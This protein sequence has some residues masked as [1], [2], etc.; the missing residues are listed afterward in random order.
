MRARDTF[1]RFNEKYVVDPVTGCWMW[2]DRPNKDGY[3]TIH[4]SRTRKTIYAHRFSYEH[5]RGPIPEGRELDHLCHDP[6]SCN[7]GV[8]CPHRRCV[9]PWH[10]E[11]VIKEI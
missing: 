8:S 9:N 3:A 4:P 11:A 5:F 10:Q 6:N 7:L 1:E 2:T